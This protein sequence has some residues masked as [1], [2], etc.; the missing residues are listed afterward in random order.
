MKPTLRSLA[1]ALLAVAATQAD[2]ELLER[3]GG[4]VYDTQSNLTWLV[5]W[6][7]GA[8][9]A[10]DDG[11]HRTDG[12]MTWGAA[13]AWADALVWGDVDDWR[14]PESSACFGFNCRTSEI[15]A[16][17]YDV[18]GNAAG[19]P[20]ADLGPF[21]HVQPAPYWTA[22]PLDDAPGMAWYFNAQGGS[23]NVFPVSAQAYAVAVRVGDV[24]P[25]PEP[26]QAW[27]LLGGLATV[28]SLVRRRGRAAA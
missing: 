22:T 26:S 13:E 14:L 15:G 11:T 4:M 23:Q 10:F 28:V 2:A 19:L 25:V 12:R 16:L 7:A 3:P 17:W 18:L 1:A 8:G 9:S 20:P 27:L 21:Q 6:N 5:D 24:T